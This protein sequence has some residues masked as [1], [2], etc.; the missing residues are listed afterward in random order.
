MAHLPLFSRARRPAR[1]RKASNAS[2]PPP[3]A[4][5]LGKI[6]AMRKCAVEVVATQHG[7]CLADAGR[8]MAWQATSSIRSAT[9]NAR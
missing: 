8:G 1:V 7:N 2:P 5:T 3:N 4:Y 6:G 9:R